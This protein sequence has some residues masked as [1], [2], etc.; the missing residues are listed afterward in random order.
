MVVKPDPATNKVKHETRSKAKQILE[1]LD[2]TIL[3]A[4]S[5]PESAYSIEAAG[6]RFEFKT[7]ADLIKA[8]NEFAAIVKQEEDAEKLVR[9]ENLGNHILV[10]FN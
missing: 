4:A 7:L 10:R 5:R 9:G 2:I 1:A 3:A 6:R 8:R